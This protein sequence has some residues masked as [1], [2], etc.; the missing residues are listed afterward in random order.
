MQ[1]EHIKCTEKN[2]ADNLEEYLN[3][4]DSSITS[5]LA[6]FFKRYL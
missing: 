6:P 2:Q 1:G 3:V 4:R 5:K